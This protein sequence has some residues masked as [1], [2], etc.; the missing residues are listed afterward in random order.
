MPTIGF[1]HTSPLHIPTFRQLVDES[2]TDG[3]V[4]H[5]AVAVLERVDESLLAAVRAG[6]KSENHEAAVGQH[7]SALVRDGADVVVC[8]CSSVAPLA[9]KVGAAPTLT[10]I[11]CP[12]A[13]ERLEAGDNEGY[14]SILADRITDTCATSQERLDVVVLAQATMAPLAD[15][16]DVGIP[17]LASPSLAVERA[18]ALLA[19]TRNLAS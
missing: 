11:F 10:T 13:W 8:T 6:G 5:E 14:L 12:E 2:G 15:T 3:D 18:L 19:G 17:V 4:V 9:E 1:L 7:L 16:L